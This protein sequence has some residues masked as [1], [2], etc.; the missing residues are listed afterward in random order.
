MNGLKNITYGGN[1]LWRSTIVHNTGNNF[2]SQLN[3]QPTL[4]DKVSTLLIYLLWGGHQP[5]WTVPSISD[6]IPLWC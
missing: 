4:T 5:T 2:Y 3:I 1:S 6:T